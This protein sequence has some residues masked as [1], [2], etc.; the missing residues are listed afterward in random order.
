MVV[1]RAD[2]RTPKPGMCGASP[3]VYSQGLALREEIIASDA[4]LIVDNKK[5]DT[6]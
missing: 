6:V 1:H 2:R 4:S 3:G 5:T